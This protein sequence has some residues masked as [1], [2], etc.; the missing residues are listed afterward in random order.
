M[1]WKSTTSPNQ[2]KHFIIVFDQHIGF[3][4]YVYEN[5]KCV[6]DYLQDTL[7]YAKE[8]AWDEY[9]VPKDSWKEITD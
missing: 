2:S 6:S 8:H 7:E 3:Y 4:L 1:K 9:Q 5:N